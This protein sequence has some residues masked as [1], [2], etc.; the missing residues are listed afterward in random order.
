M[1]KKTPPPPLEPDGRTRH[2]DETHVIQQKKRLQ[3]VCFFAHLISPSTKV[4]KIHKE[5]T[6]FANNQVQIFGAIILGLEQLIN[7]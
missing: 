2:Q 1:Q 3:A 7:L 5:A 4:N 6:R